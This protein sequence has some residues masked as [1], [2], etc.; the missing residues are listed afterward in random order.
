MVFRGRLLYCSVHLQV[1]PA[2]VNLCF[3]FAS[4]KNTLFFIMNG[5][6][7]ETKTIAEFAFSCKKTRRFN[8]YTQQMMVL[9]KDWN[10]ADVV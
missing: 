3:C 6:V 10:F 2:N 4:V 9:K 8:K 1:I 7:E 5:S